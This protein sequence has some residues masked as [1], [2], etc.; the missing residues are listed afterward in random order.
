M[1]QAFERNVK[2][3]QKGEDTMIC[4]V[5]LYK[6]KPGKNVKDEEWLSGQARRQLARLP[7]VKNLKV[8]R[9]IDPEKSP[10]AVALA[11]DFEDRA[12]LDRYRVHP[13]HQRFVKETA[14]PQ[15]EEIFRYDFEWE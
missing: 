1:I 15:V 10:Y 14:G 2:A 11:M 8:G 12:A 7:G 4:H 6:L 3:C 9:N 5:V 13:D